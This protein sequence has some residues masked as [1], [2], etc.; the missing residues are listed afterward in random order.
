MRF[1]FKDQE[2]VNDYILK[3]I[4]RIDGLI[5]SNKEE[6]LL[7]HFLEIFFAISNTI[8]DG[9]NKFL[10]PDNYKLLK[11][12]EN[13]IDEVTENESFINCRERVDNIAVCY[14]SY[15]SRKWKRRRDILQNMVKIRLNEDYAEICCLEK[16]DT[17]QKYTY[18]KW[19]KMFMQ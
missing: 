2:V 4:G 15:F 9:H 1:K 8:K 19:E 12:I 7:Y 11:D 13:I 6:K 17:Y 5:Y 3:E 16:K 18:E 10:Y 14:E